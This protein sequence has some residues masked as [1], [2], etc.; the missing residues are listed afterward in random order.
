MTGGLSVGF[1]GRLES[2]WR[3]HGVS[4]AS[5]NDNGTH[6]SRSAATQ[7]RKQTS[8]LHHSHHHDGRRQ[9]PNQ[10]ASHW[11]Q[12]GFPHARPLDN[13][14]RTHHLI[15]ALSPLSPGAKRRV[16]IYH[17]GPPRHQRGG[18]R[19]EGGGGHRAGAFLSRTPTR[20]ARANLGRAFSSSTLGH[21]DAKAPTPANQAR[22][23]VSLPFENLRSSRLKRL[24]RLLSICC[25]PFPSGAQAERALPGP[26][27]PGKPASL[28]TRTPRSSALP[29][30]RRPARVFQVA[31]ADARCSFVISVSCL[32]FWFAATRRYACASLEGPPLSGSATP[33]AISAR[34]RTAVSW[35][36]MF[37]SGGKHA[38]VISAPLAR[39]AP[40][41]S[42]SIGVQGLGAAPVDG[43]PALPNDRGHHQQHAPAVPPHR[44]LS[45][46]TPEPVPPRSTIRYAPS[47]YP[48][49]NVRPWQRAPW[50]LGLVRQGPRPP[51][52][53]PGA[54]HATKG[55]Y[56]PD[57]CNL[58]AVVIGQISLRHVL[59][60]ALAAECLARRRA[61]R[62]AV[63]AGTI[64]RYWAG[65]V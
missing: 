53:S 64:S 9:A 29:S 1:F 33:P 49:V 32:A 43:R 3:E 21:L 60:G 51:L 11:N 5:A 34:T 6:P 50:C 35:V 55:E 40:P 22:L 27:P 61:S 44:H 17:E 26:R 14:V 24:E 54:Q 37:V 62:G 56:S 38:V 52:S 59:C 19:G 65:M 31:I 7:T 63:S 8:S 30:A 36:H 28:E 45:H 20:F 58:E 57:I 46:T 42:T 18:E 48:T 4:F 12:A 15:G 39:L 47:R 25:S 41:Q 23:T 13:R 10:S 2:T 16:S